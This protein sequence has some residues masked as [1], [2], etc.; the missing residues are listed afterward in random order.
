MNFYYPN[1]QNDMWR[2]L[3]M[4]FYGDKDHF[5]DDSGKA[6]SEEKARLFC[7]EKKIGIGDTAEEVVRLNDNASDKFLQVITPFRPGEILARIPQCRAFI[8]TGQ[9]AMDTLQ[10][11][12]PFPSPKVGAFT[13]INHH[14]RNLRIYR[15]PSSSRAYP[16][17]LDQKARDYHTMFRELGMIDL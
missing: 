3:G 17:P 14:G 11:V 4:V 2:I 7:M 8:V 9:K 5:L 1:F 12:I 13:D 16:K 15:M 6:F 10:S